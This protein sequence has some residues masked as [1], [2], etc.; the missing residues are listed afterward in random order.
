M[1]DWI[2]VKVKKVS[3]DINRQSTAG[4]SAVDP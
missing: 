2:E 4:V 3:K 1:I